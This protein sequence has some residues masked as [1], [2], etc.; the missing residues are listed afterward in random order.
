GQE[1]T[2]EASPGA[3]PEASP[4]ASPM[5]GMGDMDMNPQHAN[6]NTGFSSFVPYQI[7]ILRAACSRLIPTDDSGPG[8]EEAG[9][10]YFI[11]REM[12]SRKAFRGPRYDRGPFVAG[13]ATQGDQSAMML[14]DRFRIGLLSMDAYAKS[15]YNGT[16]FASLTAEQQDQILT[17]MSGG[18]V[19]AFGSISIDSS[20][21]TPM[22]T[23]GQ[24]G[25]TAQSFFS[26]LLA[27]CMAGFFA[28][29]VHGGNRDMVGWKL[30]GFPGAHLSW[31]DQIENYNKPFQGDYISLGQYQQQVGGE[32]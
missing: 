18:E 3:S 12:D 29:P 21:M 16:G 10:V 2:P 24:L 4:E 6:T 19:D 31:A 13:E 30:I 5:A 14:R 8:A 26:L 17:D 9:V 11:D 32:S 22:A 25:I 15:K 7:S 28:D 23:G 1:S 27:Y 20:P